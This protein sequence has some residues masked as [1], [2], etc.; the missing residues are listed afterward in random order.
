MPASQVPQ[1]KVHVL[2]VGGTA[3]SAV[4]GLFRQAGWD[5]RGSDQA[6]PYPPVGDLLAALGI[7]VLHPYA[8]GNLDW[9]PDLV[10]V[11]NVIRRTN[12]EA[13]ALLESGLPYLSFP[14]ALRT[15]FFA[16]RMPLVVTGTHGKTTT[17]SLI[18]HLLHAQGFDPSF[19][20]GG[21]P[22]DFG[23]NHRLGAGRHFVVEGDEYDTAFFDKGPK[24]LHYAPQAAIVNNVEFD[25]ADIFADLDAVKQAFAKFA[26]LV[27]RG[28]PLLVP[29]EDDNARDILATAE[30]IGTTFGIERGTWQARDVRWGGPGRARVTFTLHRMGRPVGTFASPLIGDHNLRN[31]VAALAL[32]HEVDAAT[33]GLA[34]ALATF[35][36]IRKRQ[37]IK[38]VAH[39]ITVID[40]F[41][42]HPTAVRETI[43]AVRAAWPC[44]RIIA[45]FEVESNTSRRRVFQDA[46]AQA[47][48]GADAVLFCRPH[49]KPDNL[50]QDQRIDMDRLCADIAAQGTHAAMIPDI[51]DLATE[52][53]RMAR[54]GD[55]VLGMSG[56]D[57][58]GIH[59]RVLARLSQDVPQQ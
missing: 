10:I 43:A 34:Q 44:A 20:V 53:A 28:A 9:G 56:R 59:A 33:P 49:D 48:A 32:V 12:P 13:V 37:E 29:D 47:F 11:G 1:P 42:H 39:G 3:M 4:A 6:A 57:F 36:G 23:I 52:A 18:A 31:A 55:V 46:F 25:H 5:V 30:A 16:D 7:P 26:A 40:D 35:R 17:T 15:H 21:V 45:L 14:Q 38:G 2:G 41:A 19:L 50:P 51:D 8:P 54:P 27:P 22:L 58:H 24:F